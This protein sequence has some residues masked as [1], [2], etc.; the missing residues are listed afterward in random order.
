MLEDMPE[1]VLQ[2]VAADGDTPSRILPADAID[3]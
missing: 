2:Y 1:Y 3:I